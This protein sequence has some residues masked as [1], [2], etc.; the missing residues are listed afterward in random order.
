MNSQAC[1]FLMN[2]T[3]KDHCTSNNRGL[4]SFSQALVPQAELQELV[5]VY[6]AYSYVADFSGDVVAALVSKPVKVRPCIQSPSG[7]LQ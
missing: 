4:L 6:P 3:G 7:L 1:R 5:Q 2:C